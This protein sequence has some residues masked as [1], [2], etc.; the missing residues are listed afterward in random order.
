[1]KLSEAL[2]FTWSKVAPSENSTIRLHSR[3]STLGLK[4]RRYLNQGIPART[5]PNDLYHY[6][7]LLEDLD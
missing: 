2:N 3:N 7:M 4:L 5:E 6:S 1:M